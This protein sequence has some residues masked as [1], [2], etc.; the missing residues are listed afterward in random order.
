MFAPTSILEAIEIAVVMSVETAKRYFELMDDPDAPLDSIM[1]LYADDAVLHSSRKGVIRGK[2]DIREFYE[3][4]AE[5]FTGG[6]HRMQNFY[7]DGTTVVCEG[8][9]DGSTVEGREFEAVGLTDIMTFED[10]EIVRFRAYLDYAPI[11]TEIPDDP[12]AFRA[13]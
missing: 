11:L 8:L 13:E 12:P 1:D 7:Q 5:F 4:N 3:A 9:L 10:G 6:A 2:A